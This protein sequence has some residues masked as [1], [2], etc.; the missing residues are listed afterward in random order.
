MGYARRHHVHGIIPVQ[1]EDPRITQIT[2]NQIYALLDR[3][4]IIYVGQT[5]RALIRRRGQ[6]FAEAKQDRSQRPLH[7][8][9]LR[10][11]DED[12]TDDITIIALDYAT[13][14]E[15]TEAIGLANL[16]NERHGWRTARKW[17]GLDWT[18]DDIDVL[19]S[20]DSTPKAAAQLGYDWNAVY[21]AVKKLGLEYPRMRANG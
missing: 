20:M 4:V 1:H 6:H 11:L 14:R 2:R 19:E 9:L 10:V 16:L 8:Y 12:R 17:T 7:E 15:A 5:R 21:D 3:G 18:E 13:E